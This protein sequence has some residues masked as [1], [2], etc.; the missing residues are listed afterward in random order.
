[1]LT[2]LLAIGIAIA[3]ARAATLTIDGVS[4]A[5]NADGSFAVG[6][7]GR[8]SVSNAAASDTPRIIVEETATLNRLTL[9]GLT[10]TA[11]EPLDSADIRF[12]HHFG[13]GP[14][15]HV[16][17]E[18]HIDGFL[19][20]PGGGVVSN[21]LVAFSGFHNGG[22]LRTFFGLRLPAGN[23]D[24]TKQ[25]FN[26]TNHSPGYAGEGPTLSGMLSLNLKEFDSITL[27]DSASVAF[28][29]LDG[30]FPVPVPEPATVVL[31]LGALMI[32]RV[33]SIMF[34][35]PHRIHVVLYRNGG[36]S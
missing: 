14:S 12:E 24:Q 5:L 33:R 6:D 3:S 36:R 10:L 29:P 20:T 8:F 7:Y 30:A 4:V 9:T 22:V 17:A 32:K 35:V 26:A 28:Y 1:M 11:K 18:L 2:R 13:A 31:C 21:A 34:R 27:P 25:F 15:G 23:T 19:A 16:D